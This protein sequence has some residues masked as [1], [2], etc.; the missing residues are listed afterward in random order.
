MKRKQYEETFKS[1][2]VSLALSGE[3]SYA[4]VT[5]DRGKL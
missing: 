4:E 1:E 3:I 2:A 5:R